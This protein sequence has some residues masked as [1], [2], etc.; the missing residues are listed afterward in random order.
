MDTQPQPID[1]RV[2]ARDFGPRFLEPR[3]VTREHQGLVYSLPQLHQL[4]RSLPAMYLLGELAREGWL[5]LPGPP[6]QLSLLDMQRLAPGFFAPKGEYWRLLQRG[7]YA[8]NDRVDCRWLLLSDGALAQSADKNWWQ[9]VALLRSGQVVPNVAE[10]AWCMALLAMS[11]RGNVPR[12]QVRTSSIGDNGSRVRVT[13]TGPWGIY[14]DDWNDG[15]GD[16]RTGLAVLGSL[17]QP[18]TA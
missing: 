1:Y 13:C 5:L 11:R 12:W 6:R 15:R 7:P 18:S 8:A 9:Q 10:L 16:H 17:A 3:D 2:L 14:V 4:K